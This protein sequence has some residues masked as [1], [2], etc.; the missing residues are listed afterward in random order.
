MVPA[1]PEAPWVYTWS[2]TQVE[3][4]TMEQSCILQCGVIPVAPGSGPHLRCDT[5]LG[6]GQRAP[7]H[8]RCLSSCEPRSPDLLWEEGWEE[9]SRGDTPAGQKVKGV[10]SPRS[11]PTGPLLR[12]RQQSHAVRKPSHSR[13]LFYIGVTTRLYRAFHFFFFLHG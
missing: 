8:E 6:G 7:H 4:E 5:M 10:P 2:K 1:N 9:G 12:G 11:S 3:R 13:G